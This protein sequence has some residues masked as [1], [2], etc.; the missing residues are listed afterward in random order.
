MCYCSKNRYPSSWTSPEVKDLFLQETPSSS[1]TSSCL[2]TASPSSCRNT[3]PGLSNATIAG[4]AF[5]CIGSFGLIVS[6]TIFVFCLRRKKNLLGDDDDGKGVICV[7][8]QEFPA[9][10]APLEIMTERKDLPELSA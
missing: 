4:L 2:T 9:E 7:D 3:Q 6:A 1:F 8:V 10:Q 5:V